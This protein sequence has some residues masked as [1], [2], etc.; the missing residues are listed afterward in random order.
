MPP[1]ERSDGR[2]GEPSDTD[3]VT[4]DSSEQ[5]SEETVEPGELTED[6]QERIERLTDQLLEEQGGENFV[7]ELADDELRRAQ[8]RI[9]A[10][11]IIEDEDDR[12]GGDVASNG[13]S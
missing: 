1:D 4:D 11:Q 3:D 12:L 6:E 5:P 7:G 9:R 13:G 8:A 2:S 10:K